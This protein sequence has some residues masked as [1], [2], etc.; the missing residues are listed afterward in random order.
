M[1][2]GYDNL[3]SSDYLFLKIMILWLKCL[4]MKKK[5]G[6]TLLAPINSKNKSTV[7]I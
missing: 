4:E 1:S 6:K 3:N 7:C 5:I 2:S